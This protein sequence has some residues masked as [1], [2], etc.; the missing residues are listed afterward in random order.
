MRAHGTLVA[1]LVLVAAASCNP[2]AVIA[3]GSRIGGGARVAQPLQS[4]AEVQELADRINRHRVAIGCRPLIPDSRLAVVARRH[5]E[6]MVRR[7]YFSHTNPDGRD[8]FERLRGAGIHYRAAAEN[9]A[10]GQTRGRETYEDWMESTG[11]RRNI[12]NC[13]YT[14]FGIGLYRNTWTLDLARYRGD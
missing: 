5:S 11:H 13:D 12:E 14:H 2:G 1:V 7:R 9:I 4:G 6:D 3:G 8:P 10:Q